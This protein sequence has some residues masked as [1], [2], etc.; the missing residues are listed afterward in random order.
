MIRF[1]IDGMRHSMVNYLNE[2]F[3]QQAVDIKAAVDKLL[4]GIELTKI[5][6]SEIAAAKRDFEYQV[7]GVV[8]A[9]LQK[10][11]QQVGQELAAKLAAQ[12][13]D[14]LKAFAKKATKR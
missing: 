1:E 7:R 14:E 13:V 2:Y 6:D 5:V 4:D 9:E 3:M 8:R 10:A 11:T 12:A